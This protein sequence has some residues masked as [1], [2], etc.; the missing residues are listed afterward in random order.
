VATGDIGKSID[1]E[2]LNTK[3]SSVLYEPEQFPG[4]I[5]YAEEL[6]GASVL[7]FASGK[8]VFA[9]LKSHELLEDAYK[10]SKT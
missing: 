5:Y 8:V 2:K 6:E 1:I 7:V 3:L 9:G 10:C 4:A